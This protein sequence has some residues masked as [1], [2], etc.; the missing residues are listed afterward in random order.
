MHNVCFYFIIT[1][2]VRR[3][4]SG[5]G[6]VTRHS[7]FVSCSAAAAHRAFP[8]KSFVTFTATGFF[9]L[10]QSDLHSSSCP[11]GGDSSVGIKRESETMSCFSVCSSFFTFSGDFSSADEASGHRSKCLST[12]RE[13]LRLLLRLC[14]LQPVCSR[15]RGT[16]PYPQRRRLLYSK[17]WG[18]VAPSTNC[19]PTP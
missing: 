4:F 14:A 1:L 13:R 2:L 5:C 19:K 8:G 10:G 16:R 11:A 12:A 6:N 9:C 15:I 7:W 3:D 17:C 18:N